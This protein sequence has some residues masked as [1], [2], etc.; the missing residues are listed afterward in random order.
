MGLRKELFWAEKMKDDRV[1]E[2]Y[3]NVAY[4]YTDTGYGISEKKIGGENG[5]AYI[6]NSNQ[7]L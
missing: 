5:G 6:Y 3:F 7:E 4:N 1:T 2:P